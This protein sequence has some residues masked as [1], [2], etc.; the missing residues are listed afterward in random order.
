MGGFIYRVD[1]DAY[2]KGNAKS[3]GVKNR[4]NFYEHAVQLS[5]V[6][7]DCRD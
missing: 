6:W 3:R 1:K 5:E 4:N 7:A 2:A